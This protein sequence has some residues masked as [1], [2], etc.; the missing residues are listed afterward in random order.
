MS[1]I[2]IEQYNSLIK[3]VKEMQ[4]ICKQYR[5]ETKELK[6]RLRRFEDIDKG[7]AGFFKGLGKGGG[8]R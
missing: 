2:T 3:T 5:A 6:R 4:I 1:E 7:I 8:G